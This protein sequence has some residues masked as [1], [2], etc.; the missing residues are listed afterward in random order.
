MVF[1]FCTFEQKGIT[2]IFA[3]ISDILDFWVGFKAT[4]ITEQCRWMN[5]SLGL[6]SFT[7]EKKQN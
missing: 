2:Y 4:V 5:D 3:R 1:I 6:I 7:E